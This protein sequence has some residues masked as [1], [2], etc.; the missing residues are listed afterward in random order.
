MSGINYIQISKVRNRLKGNNFQ[1]KA[2]AFETIDSTIGRMLDGLIQ[3]TKSEGIKSIGTDDVI[4]LFAPKGSKA[5]QNVDVLADGE[6]PKEE[7]ACQKC[8]NIKPPFLKLARSIQTFVYDEVKAIF[9]RE[10]H[11]R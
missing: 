8:A 3:S 11:L 4:R 1:I 10:D 2:E 9:S 6:Q 5:K 7:R